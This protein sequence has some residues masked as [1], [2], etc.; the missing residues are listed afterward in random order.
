[1]VNIHGRKDDVTKADIILVKHQMYAKG[2]FKGQ[3]GN[4]M[5]L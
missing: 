3:L 1:M 4:K 2:F 5:A